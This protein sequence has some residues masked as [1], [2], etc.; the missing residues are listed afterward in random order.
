MVKIEN[1]GKNSSFKVFWKDF[2]PSQPPPVLTKNAWMV[3]IPFQYFEF[4]KLPYVAMKTIATSLNFLWS[5]E[6]SLFS[7]LLAK[8]LI[9][10]EK[11]SPKGDIAAKI[12]WQISLLLPTQ[13]SKY[14]TGFLKCVWEHRKP[15]P[16]F[17]V[18][19]IKE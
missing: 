9:F 5:S 1:Y 14:W 18:A 6:K 3:R 19:M 8:T 2:I 11:L 7:A 4:I 17:Q 15:G 13:D 16:D 12:L 10:N